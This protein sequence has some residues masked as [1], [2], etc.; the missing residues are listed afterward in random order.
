MTDLWRVGTAVDLARAWDP[1]G[2]GA[3][4]LITE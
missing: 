3:A 2:Q 4:Y 1:G